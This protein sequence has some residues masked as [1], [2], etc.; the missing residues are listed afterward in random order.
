MKNLF[1]RASGTQRYRND[2]CLTIARFPC[3]AASAYPGHVY[4]ILLLYVGLAKKKRQ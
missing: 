4:K 2:L 1:A 3:F